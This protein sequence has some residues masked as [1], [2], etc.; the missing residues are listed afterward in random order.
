MACPRSGLRAGQTIPAPENEEQAACTG[1]TYLYFAIDGN[2][3][4]GVRR[5]RN[6]ETAE[7]AIDFMYK[8]RLFFAGHGSTRIERVITHNG[9]CYRAADFTSSLGSSRQQRIRPYTP[10]RNGKVE[11]YN[12]ILAEEPVY[13]SERQRGTAVEVWNI[14]YNYHR[15]HTACGGRPPAV[16]RRRRATN[17]RAPRSGLCVRPS[18]KLFRWIR[19]IYEERF[20]ALQTALKHIPIPGLCPGRIKSLSQHTWC[21]TSQT[22]VA[23]CLRCRLIVGQVAL[24]E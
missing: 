17:I 21:R 23:P 11:R 15:P 2:T 4:F 9:S 12:R 18:I 14:H 5:S 1:Y 8:A 6:N 20:R 24:V 19:R 3:R 7:T 10:K 22:G 13:A 16:C